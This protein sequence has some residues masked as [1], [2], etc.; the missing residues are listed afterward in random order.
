MSLAQDYSGAT[1]MLVC[2]LARINLQDEDPTPA[3]FHMK[4]VQQFVGPNFPGLN[5]VQWR[6]IVWTDL[7]LAST[8]LQDPFLPY[9][10]RRRDRQSYVRPELQKQ[11]QS[12]TAQTM[13]LIPG[14]M[15]DETRQLFEGLHLESAA[16]TTEFFRH[17]TQWPMQDVPYHVVYRLCVLLSEG[18]R[19]SLT[20]PQAVLLAMQAYAWTCVPGKCGSRRY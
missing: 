1:L 11:V 16:Y 2:C 18:T 5:D 15:P 10:S 6:A 12:R 9:N 3:I 17:D 13:D 7:R 4:A 14:L 19:H 8:L 20:A